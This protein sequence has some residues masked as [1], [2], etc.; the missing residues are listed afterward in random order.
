MIWFY[1]YYFTTKK[2]IL[3]KKLSTFSFS[4]YQGTEDGM[5]TRP[6]GVAVDEEGNIIV[7]DSRNDRIQVFSSSGTFLTKFG[8]KG[9]APGEFDRPSGICISPEGII[10]VVDF[11]N[12]RVQMFW[13]DEKR[14]TKRSLLREANIVRKK[15]DGFIKKAFLVL[16]NRWQ[17]YYINQL[18]K[19]LQQL[20]R[21]FQF[22]ENYLL[23]LL[24]YSWIMVQFFNRN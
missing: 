14:I 20:F 3:K 22:H 23:L 13:K 16:C 15:N 7:A 6:N 9:T 4:S 10:I 21:E 2:Y 5:F 18:T 17:L 12:N 24:L 19:L 11:G 8:V 1:F